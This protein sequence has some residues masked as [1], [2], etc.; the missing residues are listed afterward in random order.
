MGKMG[1]PSSKNE[2]SEFYNELLNLEHRIALIE[3]ELSMSSTMPIVKMIE[4]E[5][6]MEI[7]EGSVYLNTLDSSI[8][9]FCDTKVL[10]KKE[11][12]ISFG[13]EREDVYK[14]SRAYKENLHEINYYD[15]KV[16]FK[17]LRLVEIS[18]IRTKH[19]YYLIGK[20]EP[21]EEKK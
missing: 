4:E 11:L 1:I 6:Y 20:Y 15:L 19:T 13:D 10:K 9:K 21:K 17:Y 2:N 14:K 18:A 12:G 5:V 16:G 7:N 3:K 8:K